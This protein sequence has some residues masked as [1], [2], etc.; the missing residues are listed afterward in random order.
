M[1]NY[2][3]GILYLFIRLL[4][5][6]RLT[7]FKPNQILYVFWLFFDVETELNY[8]LRCRGILVLMGVLVGLTI[9]IGSNWH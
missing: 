8:Y 2:L 4:N 7:Q 3:Y 9:A 6:D 5:S 1:E